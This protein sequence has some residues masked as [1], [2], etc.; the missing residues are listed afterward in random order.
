MTDWEV[1]SVDDGLS[2][3]GVATR[4]GVKVGIVK[5]YIASW[6]PDV[7][8]GRFGKPDRFHR[9]AFLASIDEHKS[10]K[11][12]Q[13]RLKDHHGRTI[14]GFPIDLVHED[15]HGLY[16]EGEICLEVK[17]GREAYALARQK[18]LTDF[19][20]GF[21]AIRD[22][23][24]SQFRDIMIA[25]IG[26]ASIVDEPLNRGSV[27]LE[28][29]S[30]SAIEYGDLDLAPADY[31]FKS[32]EAIERINDMPYRVGNGNHAFLDVEHKFLIGDVVEGKLLAIPKAVKEVARQI[33]LSKDEVPDEVKQNVERYLSKM[34]IKS[35]FEDKQFFDLDEVKSWNIVDLERALRA[36]GRFSKAAAKFL[37]NSREPAEEIKMEKTIADGNA[38]LAGLEDLKTLFKGQA[39]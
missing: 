38:F 2:S 22:K 39:A 32:E 5:G 28:V 27:I 21:K 13:I 16:G 33:A 25:R 35:P 1:K 4:N 15:G 19:S 34:N 20:I 3:V 7:V 9:G 37:V 6:Q 29:K 18:V 14:G 17:Q 12:R 31:E 23:V 10:R 36:T 26:E 8:P 11:D 30:M 24:G